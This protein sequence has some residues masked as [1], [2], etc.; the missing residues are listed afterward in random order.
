MDATGK[1]SIHM[2][3]SLDGY[4]AKEDNSIGWFETSSPYEKGQD[5][6]DTDEAQEKI[7]CYVMGAR[8]YELAMQL[9][10]QHGWPYGTTPTVVLSHRHF[11]EDR[12]HISFYEG[13]LGA[14]ADNLKSKYKNIW[15]VGGAQVVNEFLRLK[16][17]DEI[18]YFILPIVLGSGLR[19][20][21]KLDFEQNLNL[22]NTTA[23]KNGM[24]ALHYQIRIKN[25][26]NSAENP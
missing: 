21:E 10:E 11:D 19:F 6:Q 3:A 20:F 23:Y 2:V 18:R 4:I 1:I 13:A 24:V 16:L 14:L 12:P 17:A 22:I 7:D 9:K 26:L 5:W 8:C 15:L 25:K